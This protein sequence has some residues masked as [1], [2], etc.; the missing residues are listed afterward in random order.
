MKESKLFMVLL[1][2]KPPGR[3]TEQHDI[4]FG[5]APSIEELIPEMIDFWSSAAGKIHIDAWREVT[6]VNGHAIS[7]KERGAGKTEGGNPGQGLFFINLG[8]YREN[9]FDEA[10]YKLLVVAG[11]V[12]SAKQMAKRDAFYLHTS[13]PDGPTNRNA[14]AHIDDKYGIDIDDAYEI[15]DILPPASKNRVRILIGEAGTATHEDGMHLGY[16]KLP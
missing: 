15:Q 7:V 5:V 1:G 3:H 14:M 16:F 13:I 4:F 2:C 8:G 9:Q 10:H 6:A 12:D 11:N